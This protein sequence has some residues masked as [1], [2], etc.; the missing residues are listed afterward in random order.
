MRASARDP[1]RVQSRARAR[2]E[3]RRRRADSRRLS[4]RAFHVR[5]GHLERCDEN[6]GAPGRRRRRARASAASRGASGGHGRG[7]AKLLDHRGRARRRAQRAGSRDVQPRRVQLRV[8]VHRLHHQPVKRRARA[9][10]VAALA[11]PGRGGA[12][13]RGAGHGRGGVPAHF[14]EGRAVRVHQPGAPPQAEGLHGR[15][16]RG[17]GADNRKGDGRAGGRLRA[18]AAKARRR[19]RRRD[20]RDLRRRRERREE[21]REEDHGQGERQARR[22]IGALHED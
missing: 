18:G 1:P 20:R 21:G 8:F 5:R 17:G 6:R 12:R 2:L 10:G 22:S 15:V 14:G 9:G 3:A 11:H 13:G 4:G 7:H 19:R 16:L